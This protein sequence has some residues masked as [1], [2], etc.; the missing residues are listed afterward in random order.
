MTVKGGATGMGDPDT[1]MHLPLEKYALV[2]EYAVK[3]TKV[4]G[5]LTISK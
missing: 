2:I 3:T 4:L 1:V 5:K